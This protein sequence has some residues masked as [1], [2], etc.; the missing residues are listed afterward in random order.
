MWS[1][2]LWLL[3]FLQHGSCLIF[4]SHDHPPNM[5]ATASYKGFSN[6]WSLNSLW[7]LPFKLF[8]PS[9]ALRTLW[10]HF[11]EKLSKIS[12]LFFKC[13]R[14]NKYTVCALRSCVL[15]FS[16]SSDGGRLGK[17]HQERIAFLLFFPTPFICL[18]IPPFYMHCLP[19]KSDPVQ[20]PIMKIFC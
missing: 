20:I 3:G 1:P 17:R 8:C 4:L 12:Q 16:W 10:S 15:F 6:Y 13:H 19:S 7:I 18:S 5:K 9:K 2:V 14:P 11:S